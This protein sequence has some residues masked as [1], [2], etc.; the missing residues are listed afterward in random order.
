MSSRTL[1]RRLGELGTSY[2]GLLDDVRRQAARR[3][4]VN[5][6]LAPGEIAFILGFEELNSFSR[7]FHNWEGVT[8]SRWRESGKGH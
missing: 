2:Q 1:Q 3:L 6:N 4:L 5:T 8:P 7:A